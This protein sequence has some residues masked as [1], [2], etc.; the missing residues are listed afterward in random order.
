MDKCRSSCSM[1]VPLLFIMSFS[2]HAVLL[3]LKSLPMI[4]L[5]ICVIWCSGGRYPLGTDSFGGM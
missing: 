3:P 1:C 5:G 2:Y 4:I